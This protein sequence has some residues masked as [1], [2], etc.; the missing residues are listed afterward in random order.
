MRIG[1]FR[2]FLILARIRKSFFESRSAKG[3]DRRAIGLVVGSL[4]DVGHARVG[5]DARHVL[6][7]G[8]RVGF[9]FDHAGAGDQEKRIAA[10]EAERVQTRS[11]ELRSFRNSVKIAQTSAVRGIRTRKANAQTLSKAKG[12]R[13]KPS[14]ARLQARRLH[15]YAVACGATPTACARCDSLAGATCFSCARGPRR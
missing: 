2:S 14:D 11:R 8:A 5:G 4:E 13:R 9:A 6:S 7:H 10:A 3:F 1:S 15:C 12:C